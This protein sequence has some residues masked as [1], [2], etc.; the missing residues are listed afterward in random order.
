MRIFVGLEISNAM[1]TETARIARIAQ[2][3]MP[4]KYIAPDN[5]HC[6]IAYVGE[7]DE[8]LCA[9]VKGAL[10]TAAQGM[11]P[12]CALGPAGFFHKPEK[13][14]LY[15]GLQRRESLMQ[16]ANAVRDELK[17]SNISFDPDAFTPHITLARGVL[18]DRAGL[19]ALTPGACNSTIPC[20]TLFESARVH[21][22]L[23]YTPI[24]R[25]HWGGK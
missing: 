9:L 1:R 17:R 10:H 19:E 22:V 2:A 13:A 7:A 21:G 14:I 12:A 18:I 20:L 4:G 25:V 6:T 24:Y 16:A 15:L 8:T 11:P 3:R 5:Y 23:R